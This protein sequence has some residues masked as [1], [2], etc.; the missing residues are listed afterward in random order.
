VTLDADTLKHLDTLFVAFHDF[1]VN[2]ESIPGFEGGDILLHLFHFQAID[3]IH[4]HPPLER[5][6]AF[7]D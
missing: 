7:F 3:N 6:L 4:F 5:V 2:L 1:H